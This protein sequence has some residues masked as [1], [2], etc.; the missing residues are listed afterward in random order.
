MK[1][2]SADA[3]PLRKPPPPAVPA[4]LEPV[5][6]ALV[7]LLVGELL[8]SPLDENAQRDEARRAA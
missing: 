5:V 1:P 3:A 6:E 7:E 2:H 8:A 4:E